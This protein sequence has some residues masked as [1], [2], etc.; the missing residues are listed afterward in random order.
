MQSSTILALLLLSLVAVAHVIRFVF[1]ID[2]SIAGD[3]IP[4]WWSVP[5]AI[6]FGAAAFLLWRD[7]VQ[8]E[9]PAE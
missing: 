4:A 1:S 3:S 8:T 5:A 6:L 2:V 9:S 7:A